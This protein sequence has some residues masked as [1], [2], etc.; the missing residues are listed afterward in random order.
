MV[1]LMYILE[2]LC[3]FVFIINFFLNLLFHVVIISKIIEMYID[4]LY[5]I[6]V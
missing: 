6:I 4:M 5:C 1:K 3:Y 2:I